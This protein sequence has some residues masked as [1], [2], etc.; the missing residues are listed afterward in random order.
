MK[1]FSQTEILEIQSNLKDPVQNWD[2]YKDGM[3]SR[4]E[5]SKDHTADGDYTKTGITEL[6]YTLRGEI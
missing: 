1:D 2:D 3:H 5:T 4:Q 6:G